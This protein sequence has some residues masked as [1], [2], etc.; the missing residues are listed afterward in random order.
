MQGTKDVTSGR[1]DSTWLQKLR[2]G[3]VGEYY[4]ASAASLGFTSTSHMFIISPIYEMK[5]KK[6]Q[7]T[8]VYYENVE[9]LDN[10]TNNR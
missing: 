1:D 9:R 10:R 7:V 6:K 3:S 8:D 4:S 5:E 2:C